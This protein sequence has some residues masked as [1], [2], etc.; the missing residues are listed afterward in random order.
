MNA[1]EQHVCSPGKVDANL[2]YVVDDEPMIGE[3]VQTILKREGY[4]AKFFNDPERALQSLGAEEKK[5]ALLL[6]DYLMT[7]FN[8]IELIERCKR[9]QPELKTI[10]YSGNAREDITAQC[11][12][13]PDAFL[14][15]PFMPKT[16]TGLVRVV[17]N[18]L[19]LA[20]VFL[21][22]ASGGIL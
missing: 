5:P 13:Q 6:T 10:L 1:L 16:L 8:G 22:A 9:V 21:G 7:P 15:K 18:M 2:V 12:V 3:V 11:A 17:L 14:R 20:P 4:R 19:A